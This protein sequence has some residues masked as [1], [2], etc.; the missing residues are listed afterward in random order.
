MVV[1]A[2]SS[3]PVAA[4]TS[5]TLIS[6]EESSTSKTRKTPTTST[7]DVPLPTPNDGDDVTGKVEANQAA[8]AAAMAGANQ[9]A[10]SPVAAAARNDVVQVLTMNGKLLGELPLVLPRAEAAARVGAMLEGVRSAE[11]RLEFG[12]IPGVLVGLATPILD[13]ES[14][15]RGQEGHFLPVGEGAGFPD[16][17]RRGANKLSKGPR[18][19]LRLNN[20]T[21]ELRGS[22]RLDIVASCGGEVPPFLHAVLRTRA[23]LTVTRFV[24][25]CFLDGARRAALRDDS[26]EEEEDEGDDSSGSDEDGEDAFDWDY[27]YTAWAQRRDAKRLAKKGIERMLTTGEL[28][29]IVFQT[30]AENIP[31]VFAPLTED[32]VRENW[33][34]DTVGVG[35]K[36]VFEKHNSVLEFLV[37]N[38]TEDSLFFLEEAKKSGSAGPPAGYGG[39]D[40]H[41]VQSAC[42][43][44]LRRFFDTRPGFLEKLDPTDVAICLAHLCWRLYDAV[45]G[46]GVDQ[47]MLRTMRRT[48]LPF[49]FLHLCQH[50]ELDAR[51]VF[52]GNA[53]WGREDD[54]T[55]I[56][57]KTLRQVAF[58]ILLDVEEAH[59]TARRGGAKAVP[60]FTFLRDLILAGDTSYKGLASF[61]LDLPHEMYAALGYVPER[62]RM[63][64]E[65]HNGKDDLTLA[66]EKTRR[67]DL[68]RDA[69]ARWE[70][71]WDL[72]C[73]FEI[74]SLKR[75]T[76]LNGRT[77]R[78]LR[79][80][81]GEGKWE[82]QVLGGGEKVAKSI[83]RELDT[84]G[85]TNAVG[86]GEKIVVKKANLCLAPQRTAYND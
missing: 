74:H 68:A 80:R 25:G 27:D 81:V 26:D 43:Y 5:N 22:E 54:Q 14:G 63:R 1:P 39:R 28:D 16:R 35:P 86:G 85:G 4:P 15:G 38:A 6:V 36:G 55:S 20:T 21:G 75:R 24:R 70:H 58:W 47:R 17:D 52:P 40:Q 76:D 33:S 12:P 46:D 72:D 59:S 19:L 18:D 7:H 42:G 50:P 77:G 3:S 57:M 83:G 65:I 78:L 9:S 69:L 32:E 34:A 10:T 45:W 23:D 8:V 53:M 61:G 13:E 49:F 56:P 44:L 62:E 48:F 60:H 71:E 51:R 82:V 31:A 84:A 79:F 37:L 67:S 64:R 66:E 29:A 30:L 41:E 73:E 11:D 2:D